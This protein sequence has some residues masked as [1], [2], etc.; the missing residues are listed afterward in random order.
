MKEL[1]IELNNRLELLKDELHQKFSKQL[2]DMK[3]AN[4]QLKNRVKK[5]K[6]EIESKKQMS[7]SSSST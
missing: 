1:K 5:L 3:S 2:A 4:I 7:L 6:S